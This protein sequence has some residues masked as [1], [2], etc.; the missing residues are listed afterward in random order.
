MQA[1]D[2]FVH[3][4]RLPENYVESMMLTWKSKVLCNGGDMRRPQKW[5]LFAFVTHSAYVMFGVIVHRDKCFFPLSI[6][7]Y[8]LKTIT[9]FLFINYPL[10]AALLRRHVPGLE[11]PGVLVQGCAQKLE[12]LCNSPWLSL[13]LSDGNSTPILETSLMSSQHYFHVDLGMAT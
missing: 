5:A 7:S 2:V 6:F 13:S 10:L 11:M 4:K 9:Y 3:W 12:I 8:L 1:D